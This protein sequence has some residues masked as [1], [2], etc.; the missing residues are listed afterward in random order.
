MGNF[1][2]KG[3]K[4]LYVNHLTSTVLL[5]KLSPGTMSQR[6]QSQEVTTLLWNLCLN[7]V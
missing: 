3:R 5:S 7:P 6:G 4:D 1:S 2:N